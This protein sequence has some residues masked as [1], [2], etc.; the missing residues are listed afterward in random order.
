MANQNWDDHNRSNRYT[1]RDFARNYLNSCAPN[2]ILFT[3]GDNDTFPLWYAQEVEGVRT[4][5]RI[6]NLSLLG[7]DWY[8]D[9]M[10]KQLYDSK[11]VPFTLPFEKYVQGTNE[12]IP[13]LEKV[14]GFFDVKDIVGFIASKDQATKVQT[15]DG[16]IMDYVPTR[17]LAIKVDINK[18]ISNGTVRP[19][20]RNQV[21]SV[22]TF[23]LPE[24][25]LSLIHI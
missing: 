16:E 22:L 17:N 11:P 2:A 20:L 5:I 1:A 4:D 7:T 23:T 10:Q 3:N 6:V 15:M 14:T 25:K 18:V 9:Q 19:E 8:I 21:D 12:M 13:V 24:G